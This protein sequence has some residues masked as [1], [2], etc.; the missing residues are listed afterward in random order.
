M[1]DVATIVLPS[2]P[3]DL[4]KLKGAFKEFSNSKT[5][6]AAEGAKQNEIANRMKEEC[7]IRPEDFRV[8]ANM[9]HG[10]K[11][12]EFEAKKD[13]VLDAYDKIVS[14]K[15]P[16]QVEERTDPEVDLDNED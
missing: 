11:R 10:G 13:N 2:N 3:A 12:D 6:A 7:G 15:L 1:S 16:G 8:L 14:T 9:Y 5:R 4:L